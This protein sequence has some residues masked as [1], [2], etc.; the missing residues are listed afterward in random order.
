MT[1][2]D[3]TRS[4]A[5]HGASRSGRTAAATAGPNS[6]S[7]R[8]HPSLFRNQLIRRPTASSTNSAETL[9]LDGDAGSASDSSEIVV[10]DQHGE[11]EVENPP[12]PVV[13]DED[14]LAAMEDRQELER[15]KQ[16]LAEAVKHH[17]ASHGAVSDQPEELLEA[18]RAS[19]RAKVA[20]LA[21]DNWMFEPEEQNRG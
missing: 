3:R 15:E 4:A 19:L 10:R 11:I 13:D 5:A 14:E 12:T 7:S 21:E 6:R 18:V 1:M 20:A 9:R 16:R 2:S 17:Q 8:A